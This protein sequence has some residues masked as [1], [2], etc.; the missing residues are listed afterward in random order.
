MAHRFRGRHGGRF[1]SISARRY[2]RYAPWWS[3]W[4]IAIRLPRIV[5]RPAD[6]AWLIRVGWFIA[7]LPSDVGRS[8]LTELLARYASDPRPR[9]A[10]PTTAA[11]GVIR[12]RTPWLRLPGLRSR[13]T[14]YVRA[15][16]LY[17]FVDAGGGDPQ[18]RVGAEWFDRPGGVLRGHAW[19]TVD[20]QTI[21]APLD[22]EE[23]LALQPISLTPRRA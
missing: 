17:R 1:V 6:V 7:R 20:G 9:A 11:E 16:T 14:C 18:F 21:E 12:L 5:R 13:D 23:H 15:L 8:H 22:G 3:P 19:V 10:D 4:G 2:P